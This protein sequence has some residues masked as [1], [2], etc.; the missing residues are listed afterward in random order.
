MDQLWILIPMVN[1]QFFSCRLF[2][3]ICSYLVMNA[4]PPQQPQ[5]P[6][7]PPASIPFGPVGTTPIISFQQN[8]P[9]APGGPGTLNV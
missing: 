3:K 9:S 6:Q 2:D 7:P 5:Q 8:Q 4:P 1:V